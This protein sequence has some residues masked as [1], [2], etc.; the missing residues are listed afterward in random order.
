M[1][2]FESFLRTV[3]SENLAL[4][5]WKSPKEKLR[6]LILHGFGEHSEKYEG[7]VSNFSSSLVSFAC[8]D[9][10]GHGK[11]S[12]PRGVVDHFS[13]LVQDVDW[14]LHQLKWPLESTPWGVFAHSMGGLIALKHSLSQP[15]Y[16]PHFLSLSSPF[17]G[18]ALPVPEWKKKAAR[19]LD[20]VAPS[21]TLGDGIQDEMISRD[22]EHLKRI[23]RD[24]LRHHQMSSRWYLGA[25]E[26]IDFVQTRAP[27]LS[28]PLLLQIPYRDQVVSSPASQS[29]FERVV[30]AKKSLKIYPDMKH[31]I[32]FDLGREKVFSDQ[33][34]FLEKFLDS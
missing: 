19:V 3:D 10:R 34:N 5:L 33:W 13:Q 8:F 16:L 26:A 15:Q 7:F 31:E 17:L 28:I 22:P 32:F 20:I 27:A 2:K 14:V 21:F 24:H 18:L 12:G 9:Q 29:F 30:S 1:Q 4:R 23:Q 11:S 6:I 25:M